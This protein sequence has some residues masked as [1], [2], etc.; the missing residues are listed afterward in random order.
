MA[1]LKISLNIALISNGV[2]GSTRSVSKSVP[3]STPLLLEDKGRG[4]VCKFLLQQVLIVHCARRIAIYYCQRND[5]EV[6]RVRRD[7]WAN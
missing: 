6:Y 7:K 1:S 3:P 5:G 4:D 2:Q